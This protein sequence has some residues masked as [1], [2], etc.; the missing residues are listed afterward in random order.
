MNDIASP[1]KLPS[2]QRKSI[3]HQAA[4]AS[5]FAPLIAVLI[6]IASTA[7]RA[8]LNP[9]TQRPVVLIVGFACAIIIVIGLICGI[10]ALFG[11]RK[12]GK[13]GILAKALCGI[14]IPLLL[15]VIA[16]P[17]FLAARAKAI[18]NRQNQT[19]PDYQLSR[20]AEQ[21]N[22]QGPKMIDDDTRLEGVETLANRTILYKYSIVTKLASEIAPDAINQ[23]IRPNVVKAYNT[24]P[25]MK[26]FRDNG[27]TIVYRYKDKAGELIGDLSVGPSDLVK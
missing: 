5:A 27:V 16:V 3:Y 13:K 11:L 21:V 14:I 10:A 9:Q 7:S 23:N 19:S 15:T 20:L 6:N 18:K 25:D 24:L 2:E 1:P 12:H 17:N 8:N 4:T 22:K 26:L